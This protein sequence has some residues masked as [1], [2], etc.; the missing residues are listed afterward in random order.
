MSFF[1]RVFECEEKAFPETQAELLSIAQFGPAP[2][3]EADFFAGEH[4]TIKLPSNRIISCGTFSEPTLQELRDAVA[5]VLAKN[6]LKEKMLEIASQR[7]SEGKSPETAT[8]ADDGSGAGDSA[9]QGRKRARG[10]EH[11]IHLSNITDDARSMH[12]KSENLFA[13]VQAAS[14]FN[15]LEFPSASGKPENGISGYEWDR[16]QGPACAIACAGGTAYR[17][18]LCKRTDHPDAEKAPRGQTRDNQFNGLRDVEAAL[19]KSFWEVKNGYIN[20]TRDDLKAFEAWLA[21]EP[22]RVE[23]LKGK[24]RI[25][26]QANVQVTNEDAGMVSMKRPDG[27]WTRAPSERLTKLTGGIQIVTQTY[28]SAISVAYSRCSESEW[29]PL[30]KL[31]LDASY[32]ATLLVGILNAARV[33]SLYGTLPPVLLTKVGGGVFGNLSEWIQSAI[34]GG[35]QRVAKFGVP[36]DVRVVHYGAIES[37]YGSLPT[38]FG[39]NPE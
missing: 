35:C 37:G 30:A 17:N 15:Y 14:Q 36:L 18:Y 9:L 8:T 26:V 39:A 28:N 27:K 21:E 13:T 4:C 31:V 29:A 16:T 24:L 7:R 6:G 33:S 38:E 25:G 32:E 22:T 2:A 19:P 20:S 23:L 34:I 1:E 12:S 5:K 10:S 3:D 11:L